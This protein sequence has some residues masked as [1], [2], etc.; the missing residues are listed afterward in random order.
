MKLRRTDGISSAGSDQNLRT[1]F[2]SSLWL[3]EFDEREAI[4][5]SGS[6]EQSVAVESSGMN[7]TT[8][9]LHQPP[10]SISTDV[11]LYH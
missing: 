3:F 11:P 10:S 5:E 4:E 2:D 6:A 1:D 9:G 8:A 7:P